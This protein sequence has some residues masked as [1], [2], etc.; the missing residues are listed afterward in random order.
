[1]WYTKSLNKTKETASYI[2]QHTNNITIES[3]IFNADSEK[4]HGDPK[5]RLEKPQSC[6]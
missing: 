5:A 4:E 6:P 2:Y 1:M 3:L